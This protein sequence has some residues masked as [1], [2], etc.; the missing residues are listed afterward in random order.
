LI[1]A[2]W[3]FLV[4]QDLKKVLLIIWCCISVLISVNSAYECDV[5][6]HVQ[7]ISLFCCSPC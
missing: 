4:L 6:Y 7:N 3:K 2:V 5:H 1:L